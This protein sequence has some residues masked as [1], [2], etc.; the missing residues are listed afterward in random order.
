MKCLIIFNAFRCNF[1][2]VL[3]F[4]LVNIVDDVE[5]LVRPHMQVLEYEKCS[6]IQYHTTYP[7]S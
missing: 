6:L 1:C 7:H 4:N 5:W 3:V 2:V